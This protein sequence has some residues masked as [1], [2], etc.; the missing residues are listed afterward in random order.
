MFVAELG[1][2]LLSVRMYMSFLSEK[3]SKPVLYKST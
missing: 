2:D 1:F 3:E